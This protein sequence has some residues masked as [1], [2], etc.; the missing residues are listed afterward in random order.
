MFT[1]FTLRF[2]YFVLKEEDEEKK[3]KQ[4]QQQQRTRQSTKSAQYCQLE[5]SSTSSTILPNMKKLIF[6]T[7]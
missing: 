3:E 1:W 2:P 5:R 7:S 6:F 4:Q